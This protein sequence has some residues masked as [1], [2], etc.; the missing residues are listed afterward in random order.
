MPRW[1]RLAGAVLF[2]AATSAAAQ[3]DSPRQSYRRDIEYDGRF[4]FVRLRWKSDFGSSRRGGFSSAW[5]HDY[6]RAEQN[7]SSILR[8]LTSLDIRLDGSKILT[9]DDPELY[10]YPVSFMWEPGFWNLTDVE[11]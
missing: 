11:A 4:T 10:K 1:L 9:L 5:D 6:P 2:I 8:E 7:L 3:F